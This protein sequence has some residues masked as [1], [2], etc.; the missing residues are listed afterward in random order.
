[1]E[2]FGFDGGSTLNNPFNVEFARG[3]GWEACF[4]DGEFVYIIKQAGGDDIIITDIRE[5]SERATYDRAL[6]PSNTGGTF[7][8]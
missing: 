4:K 8:E 5:A 2:V 3:L 7:F 6:K 1:M